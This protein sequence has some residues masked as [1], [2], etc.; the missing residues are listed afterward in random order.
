MTSAAIRGVGPGIT[1]DR[2]TVGTGVGGIRVNVDSGVDELLAVTITLR[3]G[4]EP[5]HPAASAMRNSIATANG[6]LRSALNQP[7][8]NARIW[9]MTR[10]RRKAACANSN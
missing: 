4:W 6:N 3:V 7:L 5:E 8:Q 2:D 9:I 10:T 1:V